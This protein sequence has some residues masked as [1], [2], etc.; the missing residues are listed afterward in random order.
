MLV[1]GEGF[2]LYVLLSSLANQ[3]VLS[4][5]IWTSQWS[6]F[7]HFSA[8]H[9]CKFYHHESY[10]ETVNQKQ[11]IRSDLGN[12]LFSVFTQHVS[13]LPCSFTQTQIKAMDP[14]G[15]FWAGKELELYLSSTKWQEIFMP[16]RAWIAK[17]KR[18]MSCMHKPWTATQRRRWNQSRNS[19][20]KY[21]TSM[22]MHPN[23]QMDPL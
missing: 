14:S 21:K 23:F 12:V 22:T 15:T 17:G 4:A 19:S 2:F 7:M 20:S 1:F 5:L 10:F 13:G 18:I 3:P 11:L 8:V 9:H 6:L 16:R